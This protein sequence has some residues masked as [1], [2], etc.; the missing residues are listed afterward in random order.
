[1]SRLRV[2]KLYRSGVQHASLDIDHAACV[3][4]HGPSGSGKT[5]LLRAIADLD[6]ADGEVWLDDRPRSVFSGPDWRR[7][8]V[9]VAAD[10]QW[11]HE[12]VRE[13]AVDWRLD[14][15]SALGFAAEVLDWEVQRLSSGE[16]QRLSI[17][18]ALAHAP[19]ALLLDEPTANLDATNTTRVERLLVDWRA[20]SGGCVLW[21]SHDPAQRTR[22]ASVQYRVRDGVVE[23]DHAT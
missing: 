3:A 20:A 6:E 17:A 1:M 13:H 18:R 16:R 9:Y 11:W 5:L 23:R 10:S 21:V 8:V 15:L 7:H 4:L 22:V 2:E 14:D 12:T 19:S